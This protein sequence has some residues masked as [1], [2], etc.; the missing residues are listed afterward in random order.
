VRGIKKW[1]AACF[2]L[3]I[4]TAS[5]SSST[6]LGKNPRS[7]ECKDIVAIGNATAGD[8]NLLLKVRDPSR[9]G[10]QIL[11]IVPEGYKYIYPLPSWR[12]NPQEF[13]VKHKFIGVVT[14]GDA[15]P[16]IVKAGMALSDAG[17]AYGDADSPSYWINPSSNAWDDFDWIRYACQTADNEENAVTLLTSQ[18]VDELHAPA[19]SENL[20]V[21]GPKK[22]YVIEADAVR[23]DVK[24]VDD[25]WVMSNYPNELWKYRI[26]KRLFVA[27]SFDAVKE[28][29]VRKGG[30]VHLGALLGV[31]VVDIKEGVVTVRL[32]PFGKTM[33]VKA[34]EG[35]FV[36]PFWVE[37]VECNNGRA[38]IRVM[39]KFN[40]WE[41]EMKQR[42]MERYG[43]ITVQDMMNWSR[44]HSG[45][46]YGLRGMCER[47][48]KAAAICKIPYD[49]PEVLS[50]MWF[51]PDQCSGVFIPVHICCNS[52]YNAYL[53]GSAA[54]LSKNILHAYGHGGVTPYLKNAEKVFIREVN[55]AEE[56]ARSLLNKGKNVSAFMTN[57]DFE[58]QKQAYITQQ[59]L[60]LANRDEKTSGLLKTL[61]NSSYSSSILNMEAVLSEC[62]D[63]TVRNLVAN[64]V[65]S[66]AN[67]RW[68]ELNA[69]SKVDEKISELHREGMELMSEGKYKMGCDVIQIFLGMSEK[70]IEGTKNNEISKGGERGFPHY[71][72]LLVIIILG[73]MASVFLIKRFRN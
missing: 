9:P 11:C 46:L 55:R 56:T 71:I 12:N 70:S 30:V 47:E 44:L 57:I 68:N 28:K 54:E 62:R 19:V 22:A 52:I 5:L 29:E 18:A 25:I 42:V 59:L 51:A 73:V 4:L 35:A 48:N 37:V 17:I 43:Q 15:P 24:K 31:K 61:W 72:A 65:V 66:I 14:L 20:F 67:V 63:N 60:F 26:L 10:P 33:S 3:L 27:N 23:Y 50:C 38:K 7:N 45:D 2:M 16:N 36:D 64:L 32:F 41:Q 6:V 8:Y 40:A 58:L 34:G 39:Y 69:S 13:K 49:Y 1:F 53:D 21:V